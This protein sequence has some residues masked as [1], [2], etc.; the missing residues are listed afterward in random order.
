MDKNL[1]ETLLFMKKSK[2]CEK[3]IKKYYLSIKNDDY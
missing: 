1:Y 2:I 3:D